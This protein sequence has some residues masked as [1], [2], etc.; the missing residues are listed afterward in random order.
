MSILVKHGIT[1][2]KDAIV[3]FQNDLRKLEILNIPS[4]QLSLDT[5]KDFI[6]G[7]KGE[8][9]ILSNEFNNGINEGIIEKISDDIEFKIVVY[10]DDLEI[11][12]ENYLKRRVV[13][14]L[15]HLFLHLGYLSNDF[16]YIW[17]Y[18]IP[19]GY[20][21]VDKS[22]VE[23]PT[24][25]LDYDQNLFMENF[26]MPSEEFY[27]VCEKHYIEKDN[28]YVLNKIQEYF[29]VSVPLVLERGRDLQIFQ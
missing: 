12:D 19:K 5:I 28:V 20:R 2:K 3:R 16:E 13:H 27:T 15:G 21:F 4:N 11:N 23:Y 14:L 26:L 10:D 29:N 1:F 24:R 17:K 6:Q 25:I 7:I 9:V 8:L 22:Y 18:S